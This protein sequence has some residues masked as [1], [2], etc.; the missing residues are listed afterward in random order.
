LESLYTISELARM[1][2]CVWGALNVIYF[3]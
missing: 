3:R 2:D 1:I